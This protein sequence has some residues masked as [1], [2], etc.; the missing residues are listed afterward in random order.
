MRTFTGIIIADWISNCILW[1]LEVCLQ[2]EDEKQW[3]VDGQTFVF[4]AIVISIN[5]Y[6]SAKPDVC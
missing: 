1:N 5:W 3:T 4:S 2:L 6:G